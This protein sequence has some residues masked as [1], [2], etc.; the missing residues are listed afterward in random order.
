MKY[1]PTVVGWKKCTVSYEL[2]SIRTSNFLVHWDAGLLNEFRGLIHS[3]GVQELIT[4]VEL[5][6]GSKS[7]TRFDHHHTTVRKNIV[8][9]EIDCLQ[10]GAKRIPIVSDSV[11]FKGNRKDVR[12][13]KSLNVSQSPRERLGLEEVRHDLTRYVRRNRYLHTPHLPPSFAQCLQYLQFLQALHGSEPV[14]VDEYAANG[15][16]ALPKMV[17]RTKARI[18]VRNVLI[19][20]TKC[21]RLIHG[22]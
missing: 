10:V 5:H 22:I 17:A 12:V 16:R 15:R 21:P 18:A 9:A 19:R 8:F 3:G 2:H 1:T 4:R 11:V 7:S 13:A 14:H 20:N 6:C